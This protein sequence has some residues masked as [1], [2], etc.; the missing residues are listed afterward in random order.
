MKKNFSK[1]LNKKNTGYTIIETMI[2]I[3]LFLVIIIAGMSALLN[4]NV[5]HYKSQD[6]RSIMDN[7]SFIMEDISRNLRTGSTIRCINDGD[8]VNTLTTP[9]SCSTGGGI[10]FE[11]ASG[12][13]SNS[14]DQWI[15]K[16]EST[17]GGASYN[18]SKS[19]NSGA[20]WV[21][22]NASEI[23]LSSVSG[24]SV[25]GAESLVAGNQQQPL[26]IIRL[27]GTITTKNILTP[28]SLQTSISQRLID[29]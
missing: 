17:D 22:L 12:S 6:M 24:F 28:F 2:A 8:Y 25:L 21:Q 13:A 5:L 18:I 23:K 20:S 14:S 1:K 15:Y 4:A 10:V 26:V 16:I 29:N 19:T 9:K 7:L 11:E 27:V 3:S